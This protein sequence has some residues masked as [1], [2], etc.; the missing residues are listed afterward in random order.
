M[1]AVRHT[2]LHAD[3]SWVCLRAVSAPPLRRPCRYEQ[4]LKYTLPDLLLLRS[5]LRAAGCRCNLVTLLRHPL[6]QHLSWHRHFVN[7]RVPLCFWNSPHD[8]QSRM[9]MALACHG[10]PS[11][12]PLTRDHRT[13]VQAMWDAFDLVGMTEH[14]DSF[15][16][17]LADLAGLQRPFYRIQLGTAETTAA[18]EATRRWSARTCASLTADPPQ[19]LLEYIRKRM[20]ATAKAAAGFRARKGKGDSRGP[21]SRHAMKVSRTPGSNN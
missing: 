17:L 9:S 20:A 6:L 12:R 16:V 4:F 14:F 5:K 18:R 8:C 11:V 7:E 3:L 2:P 13:A 19:A 1:R 21:A 10:G 15:L